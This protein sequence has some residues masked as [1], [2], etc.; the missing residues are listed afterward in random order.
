MKFNIN[1]VFAMLCLSILSACGND[2]SAPNDPSKNI[3][4]NGAGADNGGVPN[5][6]PKN[7]SVAGSTG[8]DN[9]TAAAQ[10]TT[11][12]QVPTEV[13]LATG[14]A[15]K[16]TAEAEAHLV[17][18]ARDGDKLT[19]IVRFKGFNT[20]SYVESF[21]STPTVRNSYLENCY[22]VSGNKKYFILKD[23][24]GN[25]LAPSELR[26]R[27]GKTTSW[28]IIF[29]APPAG[30]KATLHMDHVEPLGPFTVP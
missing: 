8:V 26:L 17:K 16:G 13:V 18:A 20:F 7:L 6:P 1:I 12:A 19:V 2:S 30:E 5:D 23:S 14:L 9:A 28:S 27:P 3:V 11:A 21:Y 4:A 10:T 25:W 29:P 22:L 15:S 24:E